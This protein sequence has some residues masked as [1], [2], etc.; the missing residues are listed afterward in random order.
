MGRIALIK[1]TDKVEDKP[2]ELHRA[3]RSLENEP[4]R[5]HN[6]ASRRAGILSA[7]LSQLHI[8]PART[9][10]VAARITR[11]AA[12]LAQRTLRGPMPLWVR[13]RAPSRFGYMV[14]QQARKHLDFIR[15]LSCLICRAI[16]P[17]GS[18]IRFADARVGKTRRDAKESPT[19]GFRAC[20]VVTGC[21]TPGSERTFWRS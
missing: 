17:R 3:R 16:P 1:P 12:F 14:H 11:R 20:R 19:I 2:Q 21:N 5:P 6:P 18:A 9:N 13:K 7:I 10:L 8:T 4:A 15:S